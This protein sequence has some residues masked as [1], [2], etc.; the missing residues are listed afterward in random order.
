MTYHIVGGVPVN[1]ATCKGTQNLTNVPAM[2]IP[3]GPP[4]VI[5]VLGPVG[6]TTL[7][8]RGP[9]GPDLYIAGPAVV[10]GT[11]MSPP[12]MGIPTQFTVLATGLPMATI[13]DQHLTI[14]GPGVGVASG[15]SGAPGIV[16]PV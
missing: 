3:A 2:T 13:K 16:A 7:S 4:A 15:V 9:M 5:Q 8:A 12:G 14:P 6:S 10:P 1:A 11:G